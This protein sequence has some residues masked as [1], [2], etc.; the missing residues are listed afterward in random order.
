MQ[1]GPYVADR[2]MPRIVEA[3]AGR[4]NIMFQAFSDEWVLRLDHGDI[5]RWIIGYKFDLNRSAAG[6][7]AQDKVATYAALDAA[8]IKAMPH[9]LVRSLPHELI[10]VEE[11]H[12]A[13]QDVP[14]V[15]KPLDGTGGRDVELFKSVDDALAMARTSGEPAWALS[16]YHD[17]QAEYRLIMLDGKCLLMYE[18]T[19]ATMRGDL[20]LFNLGFGAVAVDIEDS[21]LGGTLLGIAQ[22]TM[23]TMALR[24]AAVDVVRLANDSLAVLEVNDGISM[25]HYAR[26]SDEC[27]ARVVRVYETILA[28]MLG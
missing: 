27:R 26:Q 23:Q 10:H 9:Y 28:A 25:E 21:A 17:I 6:Q 24:L 19:Q 2:L 11:L 18:K 13:L 20:K 7:L 12:K 8:G 3:Y 1:V 15:I 4:S 14:V 5:T 22:K 16:P